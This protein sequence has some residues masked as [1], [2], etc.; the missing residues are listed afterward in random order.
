MA[1]AVMVRQAHHEVV[2][3]E[4]ARLEVA[5]GLNVSALARPPRQP[6]L[7]RASFPREAPLSGSDVTKNGSGEVRKTDPAAIDSFLSRAKALAPSNPTEATG[8]MIFAL[9]AT[10]SRQPTWDLAQSLQG[11]MF[12][13]ANGFGGLAVQLVFFRG[14][15]ECRASGFVT[16]GRGLADLM[17]KIKVKGG[18]TQI[19]KILKHATEEARTSRVGA[20]IFVG[21]ASEENPD[22][23]VALAGALATRGVKA[24]MFQE[25]ADAQVRNLF[26]EIARVT[27]GAYAAF[28]P[29]AP[30]RLAELL[31]A[32]AAYAAGGR[33]ALEDQARKGG[34][35]AKA[36]LGQIK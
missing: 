28:D 2:L 12:E 20:L 14:L 30:A 32:A 23:L 26:K 15:G 16:G 9:D 17:S 31:G 35:E 3:F 7:N 34:A 11:R 21:D 6:N 10:M 19:A 22:T 4:A 13:A 33:S 36:L 1:N 27:G 5:L 8:R 29:S 24:F 18:E 25:G